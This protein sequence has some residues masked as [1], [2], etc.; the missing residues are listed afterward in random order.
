MRIVHQN[1]AGPLQFTS[2]FLNIVFLSIAM[3][4]LRMRACIPAS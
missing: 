2:L 4:H 3:F 1:V